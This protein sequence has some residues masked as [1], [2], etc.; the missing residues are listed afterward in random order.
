MSELSFVFLTLCVT[1]LLSTSQAWNFRDECQNYIGDKSVA[2]ISVCHGIMNNLRSSSLKHYSFRVIDQYGRMY[3]DVRYCRQTTER[4]RRGVTT[5]S[6]GRFQRIH[7]IY[8]PPDH[9]RPEGSPDKITVAAGKSMGFSSTECYSSGPRNKEECQAGSK[10]F[11][12][13]E[14]ENSG[15]LWLAY[16]WKVPSRGWEASYIMVQIYE[17]EPNA[18]TMKSLYRTDYESALIYISPRNG[19]TTNEKTAVYRDLFKVSVKYQVH[20][21]TPDLIVSIDEV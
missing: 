14:I 9:V 13:A 6:C 1:A 16:V 12:K 21:R 7:G 4:Y 20:T 8:A 3:G 15:G 11:F 5:S 19:L 17:R 2:T 10:G 18:D